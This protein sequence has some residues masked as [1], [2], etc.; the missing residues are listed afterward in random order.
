[1]KRQG[2]IRLL[3]IF[4]LL[5][6]L[7]L[8]ALL[9]RAFPFFPSP[10]RIVL[11]VGE[12]FGKGEIYPHLLVTL[13]ETM[14]GFAAGVVLGVW[15]GLT[16]GVN[17]TLSDLLEPIILSAYAIPKIIFL[18]LLLMIFGVGLNSKVANAALHAIFP[19]I[20]NTIIG[21]R[22]VNRL[23]VKVARSMKATKSQVFWKVHFP[24][25]VLPVF[26]GMRIGLGFAF[27]GALLA[28]LFEAKRGLGYLVVQF[29][30]RAEIASMLAVIASVFALTMSINAAMKGMENRLSH[31]RGAWRS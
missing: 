3:Q 8:F 2:L 27:L 10:V 4:I 20:L 18:P 16:L 31:W 28:E 11:A 22:E 23:L 9:N 21:T 29:Y 13:Y 26:A 12:L 30:N 24:S 14:V 15:V 5:F 7:G 1:M 25:M 6:A 17:R 19:M